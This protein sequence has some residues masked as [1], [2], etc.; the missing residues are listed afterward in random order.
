MH[1]H[2]INVHSSHNIINPENYYEVLWIWFI[3]NPVYGLHIPVI[4][5]IILTP[6]PQFIFIITAWLADGHL[7][8][9]STSLLNWTPLDVWSC[10]GRR[11]KAA[12]APTYQN[13]QNLKM[14][15]H[16]VWTTLTSFYIYEHIDFPN[17]KL[18]QRCDFTHTTQFLKDTSRK[19]DFCIGI[20]EV[21]GPRFLDKGPSGLLTLFLV[22][23][24][25]MPGDRN[26]HLMRTLKY[27]M[28]GRRPLCVHVRWGGTDQP[29]NKQDDSRSLIVFKS[30][31]DSISSTVD[32]N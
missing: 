6:G 17:Q 2:C 23:S 21:W 30:H 18:S 26:E 11:G 19:F 9:T 10:F 12:E 15:A 32:M 1:A 16:V 22:P 25:T 3:R 28:G 7:R 29:N 13:E 27:W 4:K 5:W 31:Y 8:R 14:W 20:L 24:A